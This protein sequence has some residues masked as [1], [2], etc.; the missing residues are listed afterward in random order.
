MTTARATEKTTHPKLAEI[1]EALVRWMVFTVAFAVMPVAFNA[2]TAITRGDPVA[3]ANLVANGELLL[4]S[5]A[6][7]AAAAGEL[8]TSA[9]P[10]L[11]ATKSLLIG[12]SFLVICVASLWFADIASA[13]RAHEE[14]DRHAVSV[15]STVV[16]AFATITGACCM[17]LSRLLP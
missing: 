10:A 15:G 6:I 3:Y 8:S 7:S 2:L 13:V 16:F 17:T 5:A 14:V 1:R 9:E 11:P 12:M 4:I